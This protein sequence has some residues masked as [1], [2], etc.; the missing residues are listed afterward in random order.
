[1]SAPAAA[2]WAEV[3]V[4]ATYRHVS[5]S[6]GAGAS[7]PA[8][9]PPEAMQLWWHSGVQFERWGAQAALACQHACGPGKTAELLRRR[10]VQDLTVFPSVQHWWDWL[11][12]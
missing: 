2:G 4:L 9:P 5:D 11:Q 10:G 3:P 8:G 6:G 12:T 1:L 7:G